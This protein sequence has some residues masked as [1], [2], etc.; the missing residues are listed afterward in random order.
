M[1]SRG[2]KFVEQAALPTLPT[3]KIRSH[4]KLYQFVDLKPALARWGWG[5]GEGE[6]EA[7]HSCLRGGGSVCAS[8]CVSEYVCKMKIKFD[9][10]IITIRILF[11]KYK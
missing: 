8:V 10:V 1:Y 4:S 9:D 5:R 11:N 2:Q 3:C 7:G 6:G